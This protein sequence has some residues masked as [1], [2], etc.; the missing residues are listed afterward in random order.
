MFFSISRQPET[1]FSH[2]YQL[3]NFY[4]NTDAGWHE[5]AMQQYKIVYKGYSDLYSIEDAVTF[6]LDQTEPTLLGNF[7]AIVFDSNSNSIKI[8][9]DKY[10][11]FPIFVD[12]GHK[13]TNLTQ[14]EHV[15]WTDS[16]VEIYPDLTVNETKFD[17]IE[18]IDTG[19]IS[20]ED[21]VKEIDLILTEK[22]Q[23]FLSHNKLP[24]KVFLSGGVDS[25]LVYSYLQRF[26]DQYA[27]IKAQHIDYDKFWLKNSSLLAKFWGY[28]QIHHWSEPCILTSGA[29]G[30]EFMLRSPVTTNLFLKAQN[31][32]MV[33]LLEQDS[34][35]NCLH[36]TYFS[37]S[38]HLE[39]FQNQNPPADWSRHDMLHS[40][41]NILVNDWQHWHIGNTLTWTPLRDLRIIK[42]LLR[43]PMD[44][45][46][47]QIMNSNISRTLIEKNYPGLTKCISDQ[48]N[49]G[50]SMENLVDFYF[51]HSAS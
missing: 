24:F 35:K 22:T 13:V 27:L 4:V 46:L 6:M 21:A 3:G 15:A 11:S 9:T 29:P 33:E 17:V 48:K 12:S 49:S 8:K 7:C 40:L 10:R 25:L 26:T 44:E 32:N 42:I 5:T 28:K 41:C 37:Q 45:A 50:N 16:I 51:N 47:G 31:Y 39:I 34:W 1:N 18:S 38:K 2:C 36:H 30:D 19:F 14:S 43:L 20:V 23:N